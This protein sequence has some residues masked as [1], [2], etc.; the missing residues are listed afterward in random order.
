MHRQSGEKKWKAVNSI[1]PE[2]VRGNTAK[3]T[4][5]LLNEMNGDK[6][7]WRGEVVNTGEE[8]GEVVSK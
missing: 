4:G 1:A 5:V 3:D 2:E 8:R 6:R 7:E